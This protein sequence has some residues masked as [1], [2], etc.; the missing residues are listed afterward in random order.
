MIAIWVVLLFLSSNNNNSSS[1]NSS[2][3]VELVGK[4]AEEEVA[5]I[6]LEALRDV[7]L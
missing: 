2:A 1:S 3:V 5:V 6:P 4:Q 7:L